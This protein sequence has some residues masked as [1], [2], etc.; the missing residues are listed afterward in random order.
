MAITNRQQI[1][2][3]IDTLNERIDCYEFF[4]AVRLLLNASDLRLEDLLRFKTY[5]G[6]K[7]AT[8]DIEHIRYTSIN[9]NELLEMMVN[10]MG[11]FGGNG[12]LPPH[13]TELILKQVRLRNPAI[14][15]FFDIFNHRSIGLFYRAWVKNHFCIAYEQAKRDHTQEDKFSKIIYI[16]TG[17]G[18]RK[19]QKQLP[20][21]KENIAFYASYFQTRA[22]SAINLRAMVYHYF[23]IDVDIKEFQGEWLQLGREALS[24]LPCRR[25]PW[26]RNMRLG[27]NTNAGDRVW[28]E[29]AKFRII[30]KPATEEQYQQFFPGGESLSVLQRLVRQ[31]VDLHLRFEIQLEPAEKMTKACRLHAKNPLRLSWQT[32]LG[33]P[34]GL[35]NKECVVLSEES[36]KHY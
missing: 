9:E 8:S 29:N 36:I 13:Y 16:L 28:V 4:Q 32:W 11:V 24:Y 22:R 23:K 12:V 10:F 34:V 21:A 3:L 15:D 33:D 20:I 35:Q 14:R 26:G 18:Q 7:F 30:L 17:Y 1:I 25:Y 31:Y 27:L 19:L 6:L 5:P 2:C